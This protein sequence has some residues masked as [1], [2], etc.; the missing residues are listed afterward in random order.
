MSLGLLKRLCER[1]SEL[2]LM[3]MCIKQKPSESH[4]NIAEFIGTTNEL[5][6]QVYIIDINSN[7]KV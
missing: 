1:V 2:K 6:K 4:D 3:D 7:F 5:C